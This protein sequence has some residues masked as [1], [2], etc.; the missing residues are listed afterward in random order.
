MS[1]KEGAP[2]SPIGSG[3]S[4]KKQELPEDLKPELLPV[5]PQFEKDRE[6]VRRGEKESEPLAQP[7]AVTRQLPE[8]EWE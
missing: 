2:H 5:S 3:G 7:M 8:E 1:H 6:T 4:R